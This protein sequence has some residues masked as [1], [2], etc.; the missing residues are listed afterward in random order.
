[1]L[2][3]MPIGDRFVDRAM[4]SSVRFQPTFMFLETIYPSRFWNGVRRM[5]G[6]SPIPAREVPVVS[7]QPQIEFTVAG[8]ERPFTV[9]LSYHEDEEA[10]QLALWLR[11]EPNKFEAIA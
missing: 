6:R 5:L 7:S 8:A 1:M 9:S 10:E 11:R 3:R 4:V 2:E